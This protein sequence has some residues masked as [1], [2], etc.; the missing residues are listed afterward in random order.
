MLEREG[1]F[2]AQN[3]IL[4]RQRMLLV[5]VFG[6]ACGA[7]ASPSRRAICGAFVGA[8]APLLGHGHQRQ[9]VQRRLHR[10]QH[11]ATRSV[12]SKRPGNFF[13]KLGLHAMASATEESFVLRL[14]HERRVSILRNFLDTEHASLLFAEISDADV[15]DRLKCIGS[16]K[17]TVFFENPDKEYLFSGRRF[18]ADNVAMPPLVA[19]TMKAAGAAT[20]EPFNGAV[21]NVYDTT[22]AQIK[23]HDDGEYSVGPVVASYSLGRSATMGFRRKPSKKRKSKW[24]K[25]LKAAFAN[26][27]AFDE[28]SYQLKLEQL[29][30]TLRQSGGARDIP[31]VDA[32]PDASGITTIEVTHNTL[33]VMEAGV[34]EAFEHRIFKPP[35]E[36]AIAPRINLTF[37]THL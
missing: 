11:E 27:T 8:P 20:R 6:W 22:D 32:E 28:T 24:G 37:H 31:E 13:P 25:P 9:Q 2:V 36:S 7:S 15:A 23:W 30:L 5:A 4:A 10:I 18:I 29:E 12:R 34:Q 26:D 14:D 3:V 1:M 17:T 21:I 16:R 33:V 19:T 35:A